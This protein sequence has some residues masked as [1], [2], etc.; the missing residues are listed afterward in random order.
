MRSRSRRKPA[1]G[2]GGVLLLLLLL[3]VLLLLLLVLVHLLRLTDGASIPLLGC[4]CWFVR[5]SSGALCYYGCC[6]FS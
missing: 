2:V 4:R 1:R 6:A 5:L 3:L